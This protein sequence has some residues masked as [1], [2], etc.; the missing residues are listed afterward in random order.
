MYE[1][2]AKTRLDLPEAVG[3]DLRENQCMAPCPLLAF[4]GKDQ[5]QFQLAS[6]YSD[7]YVSDTA[8]GT[9]CTVQY[10]RFF[11]MCLSGHAETPCMTIQQSKEWKI[12]S[13]N[14]ICPQGWTCPCGTNYRTKYG[15][16]VEIVAPGVDG[17]LYC[18]APVPD[19]HVNEMRAI[20]HELKLKPTSPMALYRAVPVCKPS[21]T[22][23]IIKKERDMYVWEPLRQPVDLQVEKGLPTFPDTSCHRSLLPRS[24]KRSRT[25][26]SGRPR[27]WWVPRRR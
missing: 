21:N 15:V 7:E 18:R 20:M 1:G 14:P 5:W 26:N 11:F 2:V 17:I 8:S 4:Q 24:R 10:M 19:E 25:S 23:L 9:Y 27:T 22:I 12:K 13:G 3:F 16:I 6:T